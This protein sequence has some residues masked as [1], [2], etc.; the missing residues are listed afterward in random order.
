M[1]SA[2]LNPQQLEAVKS[3][4]GPLMILAGAGTGKTKVITC[5]IGNIISHGIPAR[6]IAAMTFTNKAAT[7]MKTRI[8]KIV[9]WLWSRQGFYW[10]LP[11]FLS[12]YS[13]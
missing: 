7:E 13:S 10:N 2:D 8:K 4:T 6:K 5:R 1:I 11:S 9:P 12:K 3:I